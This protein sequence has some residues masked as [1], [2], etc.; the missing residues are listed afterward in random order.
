MLKE[1]L[2]QIFFTGINISLNFNN[3]A[4]YL[5]KLKLTIMKKFMF[6]LVLGVMV[7]GTT[8]SFGQDDKSDKKEM[9]SEKKSMKGK[10]HKAHKKAEKMEKKMDKDK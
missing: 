10:H 7:L 1:T 3:S 9:K 6:A 8:V 5:V 2:K 4:L